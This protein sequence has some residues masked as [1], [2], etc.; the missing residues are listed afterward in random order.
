MAD[1]IKTK[2]TFPKSGGLA[3]AD[4]AVSVNAGNGLHVNP[5]T[6]MVEVPVDTASGLGYGSNGMEVEVDGSTVDFNASGQL[7]ALG[8]GG[9]KPFYLFLPD[10]SN[11]LIGDFKIQTPFGLRN[12]SSGYWGTTTF[13]EGAVGKYENS[14]VLLINSINI[15]GFYTTNTSFE[16]INVELQQTGI[17][18][19]TVNGGTYNHDINLSYAAANCVYVTDQRVGYLNTFFGAPSANKIAVKVRTG[20]S[21]HLM[22]VFLNALIVVTKE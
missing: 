14:D 22:K 16:L 9:L 21:E 2:A 4:G 5:S 18:S 15:P 3:V 6:G 1:L 10:N 7:T 13:I 12:T 8:G 11:H 17:S 19:I 20:V